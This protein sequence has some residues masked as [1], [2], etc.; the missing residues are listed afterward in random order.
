MATKTSIKPFV[1]TGSERDSRRIQVIESVG[2][3]PL[4]DLP[5]ISKEV[6]PVRIAVKAEWYNPGGSVKDR[7]ALNMILEGE[8]SGRLTSE[9]IIMDATSGNTGIAYAMVGAAL[10]YRVRLCV[11]KNIGALRRRCLEAY[12]A[13]LILTDPTLGSDGAI[14]EAIRQYEAHGPDVYFYPDQYSNDANWQAHYNSTAVEIWNQTKGEIT[15]FV[16]GLGTSGTLCGNGRRLKEF[17]K[18]IKLVSLQPDSPMHGLEGWKHMPTAIVPKIYDDTVAD[19]ERTVRTEDAQAMCI[20]LA[21]E[22]GVQVSPSAGANIHSALQVARD[23][24]DGLV[25]AIGADGAAKYLDFE[26]W[27]RAKP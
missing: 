12:G 17:N 5:N 14:E 21:R 19:E 1:C 23:L 8:K 20:R 3:T 7:P 10:G 26:F 9:K 6:A 13:E 4:F 18:N 25:V 24:D 15:H 22:E 16:A 2:N 27:D 11:P